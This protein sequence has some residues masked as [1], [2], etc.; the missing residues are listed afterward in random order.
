MDL[1]NTKVFPKKDYKPKEM[2][3]EPEIKSHFLASGKKTISPEALST[4]R[5]MAFLDPKYFDKSLFEAFRQDFAARNEDLLFSF[6][7]TADAQNKA[8]VRLV[9]ASLIQL[10]EKDKTLSMAHDIQTSVLADTQSTGLI[11]PLFNVIV[12]VL[13][14]LWPQMVCVPDRTVDQEEFTAATAPGTNYEAYLHNRYSKARMPYLQEYIRYSRDNVWGRRDDL[15]PHIARLERIFYHFD[16]D[17]VGVC[18][19]IKFAMLLAEAAWCVI[20]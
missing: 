2:D 1:N 4:L 20:F 15:V 14:G 19:T 7:T 10:N 18:A 3:Y 16:D 11:S 17:M 12:K 13:F 5:V 8:Y 6:P 9:D